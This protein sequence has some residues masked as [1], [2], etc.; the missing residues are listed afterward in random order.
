MRLQSS[1][2]EKWKT[3]RPLGDRRPRSSWEPS[4]AVIAI[5]A[6]PHVGGKVGS[7]S[8]SLGVDDSR[9]AQ[10]LRYVFCPLDSSRIMRI[11]LRLLTPGLRNWNRLHW[12]HSN[13]GADSLHF[14]CRADLWGSGG[15]GLIVHATDL[16]EI[17][18]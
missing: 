10:T 18:L 13:R 6:V 12:S 3:C 9:A 7:D 8:V 4:A 17:P 5:L 2:Q 14:A 16:V 1:R 11:C 15:A